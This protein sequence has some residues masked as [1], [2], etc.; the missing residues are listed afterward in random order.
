MPKLTINGKPVDV[1]DGTTVL[2]AAKSIGIK[3][4]HFCYHPGLPVDGN[5]RLCMVEMEVRGRKALMT[6]CNT[7]VSEGLV[8]VTDSEAALKHQSTALEMFLANHPLDCPICDKAGEC[9]L[10]DYY[11]EFSRKDRVMDFPKVHKN[12][13][14]DLGEKIVLDQERC[15]LCN[16]CVR[17]LREVAGNEELYIS[18]R[19]I[20]SN[21]TAFPGKKLEGDYV[22]NTTDICPVGALTSRDF[23]FKC[24]TWFLER[25]PTVCPGCARGC[26]VWLDTHKGRAF[27]LVPRENPE[28]NKHWMC[29]EGRLTYRQMNFNRLPVESTEGSLEQAAEK[30]AAV[31]KTHGPQ[32]VA[33]VGSSFSTLESNAMLAILGHGLDI[34]NRAFGNWN[35]D[36]SEDKL[37]RL[38][39]KS[40]NTAGLK[41]LGLPD[42]LD[43]VI[44]A[45]H[46]GQ[47][48]LV[49]IMNNNLPEDK[50]RGLSEKAEVI[51][52]TP[53]KTKV[54]VAIPCAVFAEQ[55]GCFINADNRIQKITP[56]PD[57]D[58]YWPEWK[59]L[60]WLAKKLDTGLKVESLGDIREIISQKH[61]NFGQV[62]WDGLSGEGSQL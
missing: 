53:F 36:G 25:T 9:L 12:K 23:R 51:L 24:R 56:V 41:A 62:D 52:L 49:V 44:K 16:R 46:D 59:L 37:L 1:P 21:I 32:S 15:V 43:G 58:D 61:K 3:I 8:V 47:I 6:S 33:F 60:A 40:P 30:L 7:P 29:D 45:V 4:P 31:I 57:R 34:K 35:P 26:N 27:R 22:L 28:V 5:C 39:D 11:Y 14:V 48:K 10:Q 19:G 2:E 18:G 54:T 38:K 20:H 17:F 55:E 13:A 50:M 42:D